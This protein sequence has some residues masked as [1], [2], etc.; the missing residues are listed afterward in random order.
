[1]RMPTI[2]DS[3]ATLDPGGGDASASGARDLT[4]AM[5][6]LMRVVQ[7]RDR[8][9]ACCYDISVSQCYALKA[10]IDGEGLTVNELAAHLYLDKS[11]ASRIASGLFEKGLVG[12]ARDPVDGRIVRLV[13]SETGRALCA[14]IEQDLE[15]EYE[16]LLADFGPEVRAAMVTVIRR[17]SRSMAS[18]VEVS[19]G[20]CCVVR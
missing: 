10:I 12:R 9:R 11:T 5:S 6:E 3:P 8:D 7:F 1:M 15:D 18:R 19:G 17:L 14:R 4:E 2:V 20:N 13:P 16:E